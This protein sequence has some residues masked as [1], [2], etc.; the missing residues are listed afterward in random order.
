[1]R[2]FWPP[3]YGYSAR[4]IGV[5]PSRWGNALAIMQWGLCNEERVVNAQ[6]LY[7][8]VCVKHDWLA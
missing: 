8:T 4:L 7:A 3:S 5:P 2:L 6:F 1:M